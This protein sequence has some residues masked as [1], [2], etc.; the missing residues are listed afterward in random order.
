MLEQKGL[1][2][3][4]DANLQRVFPVGVSYLLFSRQEHFHF[5]RQDIRKKQK[6]R[7]HMIG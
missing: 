6:V 7:L 3:R 4:D 5:S 1:F 2:Q